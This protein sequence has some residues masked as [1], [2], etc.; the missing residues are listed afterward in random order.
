MITSV[1]HFLKA[2]NLQK[3]IKNNQNQDKSGVKKH[4][5]TEQVLFIQIIVIF[6]ALK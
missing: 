4:P 5:K 2:K 1:R 6:V 3:S